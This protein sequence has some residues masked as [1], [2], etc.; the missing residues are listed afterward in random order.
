MGIT[1]TD[2]PRADPRA[3]SADARGPLASARA[4]LFDPDVR[5]RTLHEVRS[6]SFEKWTRW[7][8]LGTALGAAAGSF[9]ALMWIG[10]FMGWAAP[11]LPITVDG[12]II[13]TS[14]GIIHSHAEDERWWHRS[15]RWFGLSAA[16]AVSV[17]GNVLHAQA[18]HITYMPPYAIIVFGGVAPLFAAYGLHVYGLAITSDSLSEN[19]LAGDPT[20]VHRDV[21]K[22]GDARKPARSP[23]AKP[24]PAPAD[25][26]VQ[27][28]DSR[29]D[30]HAGDPG[31]HADKGLAATRTRV[32]AILADDPRAQFRAVDVCAEVKATCD[33]ATGR[34]WVATARKEAALLRAAD[35]GADSGEPAT[36]LHDLSLTR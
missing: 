21:W 22:P 35:E 6:M 23:R 31:V 10:K 3:E 17:W 16:L 2:D 13:A 19:I 1:D 36:Y 29:S 27:R 7:V 12:L 20:I 24:V 5:Q 28:A 14:M 30:V 11:L 4:L 8:V 25:A 18:Q 9:L 26:R 32:L 34:R 15:T 33:P